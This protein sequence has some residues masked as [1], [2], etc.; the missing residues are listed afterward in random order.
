MRKLVFSFLIDGVVLTTDDLFAAGLDVTVLLAVAL[1]DDSP[2]EAC[3][4][5]PAVRPSVP[6]FLLTV[7]LDPIPPLSE[8]PLPN[9]LSEPVW[10]LEPYHASLLCSTPPMC[11]G[12]CT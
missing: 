3:I 6:L 9:T 10:C 5:L 2:E 1:P 7:L 12:P 11:P 4:R 8:E